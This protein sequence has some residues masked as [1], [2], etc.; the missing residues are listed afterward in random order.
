MDDRT[1]AD[2]TRAWGEWTPGIF[3]RASAP[4]FAMPEPNTYHEAGG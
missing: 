3:G 1:R 4:A 2:L